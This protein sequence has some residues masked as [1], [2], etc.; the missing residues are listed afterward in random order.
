MH[1]VHHRMPRAGI[2]PIDDPATAF[3]TLAM[4]V[5][6]PLRAETIALVLDDARCGLAVAVVTGTDHADDV[7]EVVE[8]LVEPAAHGGRAAA[9]VVASVRP[10]ELD[11]DDGADVDRWLEM[12]EIADAAGIELVEWFVVDREVSC[13]RDRLGEPPRW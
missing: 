11:S 7:I 8:R 12:S 1:T 13:P 9:L 3:A 6:R 5:H 2:D 10:D 4:A